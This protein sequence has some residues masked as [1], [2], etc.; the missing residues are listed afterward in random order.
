MD[1]AHIRDH[2]GVE[3]W[4]F[5]CKMLDGCNAERSLEQA[6]CGRKSTTADS[7]VVG[8]KLNAIIESL[9]PRQVD[10]YDEEVEAPA[11]KHERQKIIVRKSFQDRHQKLVRELKQATLTFPAFDHHDH[12]F[13]QTMRK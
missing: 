8:G 2:I 6:N 7:D 9:D 1:F 12:Q 3:A 11:E 13:K 4:E 10:G 5:A